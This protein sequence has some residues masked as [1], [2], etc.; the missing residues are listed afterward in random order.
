MENKL[1][2]LYF[3]LFIFVVTFKTSFAAREHKHF[4]FLVHGIAGKPENFGSL[5]EILEDQKSYLNINETLVVEK[6]KYNTGDNQIDVNK[7]ALL[8]SSFVDE[9]IRAN[10]GIRNED[11]ISFVV[12]SQGGLIATRMLLRSAMQDVRY[13]PEYLNNYFSMVTLGTPFWGSKIA[14]AGSKVKALARML[15][16]DILNFFG[17]TQLDDLQVTSP[18]VDELR[19]LLLE[20]YAQVLMAKLQEQI[21]FVH[22]AGMPEALKWLRPFVTGKNQFEDDTAVPLPS[23]QLD[24]SYYVE[25]ADHKNK[26]MIYP[27]DFFETAFTREDNFYPVS[28]FHTAIIKESVKVHGI[29][30]FPQKCL[31]YKYTYCPHPALVPVV[32][33][34]FGLRKSKEPRTDFTSFAFDLRLRFKGKLLSENEQKKL[35]IKL[36]P[37]LAT[38]KIGKPGELYK[39]VRRWD[40]NGEYRLYHTGFIKQVDSQ[41]G[42]V[43]MRIT[44]PG[45]REK[46]VQIPVKKG[47]TTHLDLTL[48]K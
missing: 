7:I 12:H 16:L 19:A 26:A 38:T 29:A 11:K 10:G 18:A 8:L 15:G 21:H 37:L 3:I 45:Y 43:E 36:K 13:H 30:Y 1:K 46:S 27:E 35:K 17:N 23:T 9:K 34:L 41:E 47:R 4:I 31:G 44:L 2:Y 14:I 24:F 22:V 33:T 5:K 28:A 25:N 42:L 40:S 32:E 6:F 39:R 20:P 48:L